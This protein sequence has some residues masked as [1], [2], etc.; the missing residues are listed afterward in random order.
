LI[1]KHGRHDIDKLKEKGMFNYA[2]FMDVE[3]TKKLKMF[4]KDKQRFGEQTLD[5][6]SPKFKLTK[7]KGR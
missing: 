6:D 3:T 5:I 2:D 1:K 4:R 7:K